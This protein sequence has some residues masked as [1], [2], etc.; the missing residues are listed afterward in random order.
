MK[1]EAFASP[2]NQAAISLAM[3]SRTLSRVFQGLSALP[4]V[5]ILFHCLAS[6]QMLAVDSET[7]EKASSHNRADFS[8]SLRLP[9]K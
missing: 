8:A 6:G 7:V 9:L 3:I 4:W 2:S 5:M 1:R